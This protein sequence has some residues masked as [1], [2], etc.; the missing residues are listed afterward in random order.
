MQEEYSKAASSKPF[1]SKYALA[2]ALSSPFFS[3]LFDKGWTPKDCLWHCQVIQQVTNH[4]SLDLGG[5]LAFV[6]SRFIIRFLYMLYFALRSWMNEFQFLIEKKKSYSTSS[7]QIQ[8][9]KTEI[10]QNQPYMG[11]NKKLIFAARQGHKP[12]DW[13]NTTTNGLRTKIGSWCSLQT[14]K[15]A[16]IL[17][18]RLRN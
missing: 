10:T 5:P 11:Q 16:S 2:S 3:L 9:T 12:Y 7:N 1:Q 15:P 13:N 14:W 8:N 17:T 4:L 6:F 18:P